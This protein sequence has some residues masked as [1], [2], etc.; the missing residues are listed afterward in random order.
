MNKKRR[1]RTEDPLVLSATTNDGT[2]HDSDIE[3]GEYD[4]ITFHSTESIERT[5]TV[6]DV[7]RTPFERHGSV[8]RILKHT[9]HTDHS[10]SWLWTVY[11]DYT[12]DNEGGVPLGELARQLD[13]D[14]SLTPP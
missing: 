3:A 10:K 13:D 9:N 6:G 7:L 14:A 11:I 8:S 5:I 2:T 1:V 4:S 12:N